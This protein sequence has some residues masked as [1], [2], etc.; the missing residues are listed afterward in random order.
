MSYPQQT[1]TFFAN[2]INCIPNEYIKIDAGLLYESYIRKYPDVYSSPG[3]FIRSTRRFLSQVYNNTISIDDKANTKGKRGYYF[4]FDCRW[5]K[6]F[7]PIA[8]PVI[9]DINNPNL[10]HNIKAYL[11]HEIKPLPSFMFGPPQEVVTPVEEPPPTGPRNSFNSNTNP[12][13]SNLP[14]NYPLLQS[15]G[16]I[17]DFQC[18]SNAFT[19]SN[20]L[21]EL[22]N[23]HRHYNRPMT[24]HY[25]GN[26][27][28]G[29]VVT[30]PKSKDYG[31]FNKNQRKYKWVEQIFG[32]LDQST[33]STLV[34]SDAAL[35]MIRHLYSSCHHQFVKVVL[36]K[37]F[38]IKQQMTSVEAAAM[39]T[40]ANVSINQAR[41]ILRHLYAKFKTRLQVP[42]ISMATLS[43]IND[44]VEPTFEE[45]RYRKEGEPSSK[46]AERVKYWYCCPTDLMKAD[47]SCLLSSYRNDQNEVTFKPFGY[48]NS[49]FPS[50]QTGVLCIIGSDHGGGSSKYLLRTNYLDSAARRKNNSVEYGTRT[51]QFSEIQCKKDVHQIQAKVAP[52]INKGITKLEKSMLIGII[53]DKKKVQ[54]ELIPKD[55]SNINIQS[56][57]DGTYLNYT[58]NNKS[59]KV[60]VSEKLS[61]HTS[62]QTV[63]HNFKIVVCGDLS[64]YATV[65]G[66][67]G[68]LHVR[69]PY[70]DLTTNEW[71]DYPDT[72][73]IM[74]L[75]KLRELAV[76]K[77]SNPKYDSKGVV[78][79]PQLDVEPSMYIVPILHLLI[80]LI[81]KVWTSLG[82]FLDDFVETITREEATIKEECQKLKEELEIIKE[83]IEVHTTN[84]HV[85]S[86]EIDFSHE[87]KEVYDTSCNLLKKLEEK[88]RSKNQLLKTRKKQLSEMKKKRIGDEK[89]IEYLLYEILEQSKIRKQ[90]FHGGAMN[91]VAC[92]RLLDDIEIIFPKVRDLAHER[93][94]LNRNRTTLIEHDKIDDILDQ[95][96]SI[97]QTLDVVF[98]LL[99]LVDPTEEEMS[100][101]EKII[102]QLRMQWKK[103]ELHETP[104]FHIL[105]T[106]TLMQV[107]LFGG[108]SDLAEDFVEKSH[109]IGNRLNHL[110][111]RMNTQNYRDQEL[112]KLRRRW[113]NTNP[114]V[115]DQIQ[116]V[117]ESTRRKNSNHSTP[118]KKFKKDIKKEA[119]LIKREKIVATITTNM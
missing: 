115:Q 58:D 22:V 104:K 57:G 86:A 93:A 4:I 92:R 114:L 25:V 1:Y 83:E 72:G 119:K 37:G 6:V 19:I 20:L 15:L 21:S 63:I 60:R 84:K 100:N 110:T 79:L 5:R 65:T 112:M 105:T 33:N 14:T 34:E 17:P 103:L 101:M 40:E 49:L 32:F 30:V 94:N 67:D 116:Q 78:M 42:L 95:F 44:V 50:N 73:N 26:N 46:I 88:K 16:V 56:Q 29:L 102:D 8:L 87:A 11:L 107:R 77:Q 9:D 52:V 111:S 97:F 47:F 75:A 55:A 70:C 12:V 66:R 109:Q 62:Y 45:F 2:L 18:D 98:A 13:P 23:S 54:C 7:I 35:W 71:T 99:R 82:H 31:N 89:G 117:K 68:H 106:H 10:N 48:Y 91:G 90:A 64:F 108:I 27:K 74:T 24:F 28:P 118:T 53:L 76:L 80:G 39:W 81:N 38:C 51:V 61:K 3:N 96:L 59:Y 43:N 69:C 36:E 85:A 113:L 41:I